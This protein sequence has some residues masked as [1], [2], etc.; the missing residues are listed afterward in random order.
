M[1]F[2]VIIFLG[3][4]TKDAII[5]PA[6]FGWRGLQV[7]L[8]KSDSKMNYGFIFKFAEVVSQRL[9]LVI[10]SIFL[11]PEELNVGEL[12]ISQYLTYQYLNSF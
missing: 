3:Y 12:L 4:L 5:S 1:S 9:N 2:C 11:G 8:K 7:E 6:C 10:K